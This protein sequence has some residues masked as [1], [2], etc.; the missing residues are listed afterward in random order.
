MQRRAPSCK[1]VQIS[2][3][4]RTRDG[5]RKRE[6]KINDSEQRERQTDRQTMILI[7][8]DSRRHK[9]VDTKRRRRPKSKLDKFNDAED[10][11]RGRMS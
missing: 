7:T 10:R 1:P 5:E 8:K 4:A 3:E 6:T 2:V 11:A 9:V